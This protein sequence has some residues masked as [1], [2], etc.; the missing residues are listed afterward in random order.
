MPD[1]LEPPFQVRIVKFNWV[2]LF[3]LWRLIDSMQ[4]L[5][6]ALLT[7]LGKSKPNTLYTSPCTMPRVASC[8]ILAASIV[9]DTPKE[10]NRCG[11]RTVFSGWHLCIAQGSSQRGLNSTRGPS[12]PPIPFPRL[13]HKQIHCI[14]VR[15]VA[16]V[17]ETSGKDKWT[18]HSLAI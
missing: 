15:P 18:R 4:V 14:K 10:E 8:G 17:V 11:I 3:T 6:H 16:N 12:L 1:R 5:P 13:K 9:R 7:K 2:E